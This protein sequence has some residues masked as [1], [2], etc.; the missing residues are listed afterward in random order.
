MPP[1]GTQAMLFDIAAQAKNNVDDVDVG[2][3]R[4]AGAN[5]A[6]QEKRF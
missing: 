5:V 1:S 3:G 2:G 4:G 6:K